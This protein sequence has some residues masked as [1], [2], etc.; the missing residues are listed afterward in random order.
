MKLSEF[1]HLV[2]EWVR[3]T[4]NRPE[5]VTLNPEG[6]SELYVDFMKGF[7][8]ELYVDVMKGFSTQKVERYWIDGVRI[9]KGDPDIE[10]IIG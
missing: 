2:R 3:K 10:Y 6:F 9:F 7:M 8:S 1:E 4:G 5:S